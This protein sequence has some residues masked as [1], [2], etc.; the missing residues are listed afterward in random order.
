MSVKFKIQH[1]F[2][3]EG[4]ISGEGGDSDGEGWKLN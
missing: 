2:F 1:I 4:N 3:F